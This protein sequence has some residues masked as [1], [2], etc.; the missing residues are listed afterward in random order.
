MASR[1]SSASSATKPL[2]G[3]LMGS[4][5][6]Y[7]NM[8]AACE[9]MAEL[10]IAHEVRVLSAH[11]TPD[12]TLEYAATARDRGL[13]IIIAGAGGAAHLPGVIAAK[14][15]LPVIGVPMTSALNG[16]DSLLA[17]AQMPKGVPVATMAIGKSGAAN[18]GLFAAQI[19]ALGDPELAER[20]AQ[21]RA[22]RA[23]EVLAQKLP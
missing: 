3:V 18:A 4:K 22:A 9:V 15:L 8:S 2:V 21:W 23:Q 17:I 20:L 1:T 7:E 19:I 11:R 10:K 13:K 12:Q 5:S 14:T 16:L 6:D